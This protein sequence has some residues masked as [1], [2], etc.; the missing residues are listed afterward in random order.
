MKNLALDVLN[1][2]VHIS[3][4]GDPNREV[5][6][7]SGGQKHAIAIARAVYFKRRILLPSGARLHI[8]VARQRLPVD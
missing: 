1:S 8:T 3:G 5:G 7:L 4:I 6:F 2:S